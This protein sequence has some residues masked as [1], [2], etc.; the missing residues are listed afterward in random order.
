MLGF[1]AINYLRTMKNVVA[2]YAK[3]GHNLPAAIEATGCDDRFREYAESWVT[4]YEYAHLT[5]NNYR[6]G[7]FTLT[8]CLNTLNDIGL[9]LWIYGDKY[10]W[11]LD[12]L[13]EHVTFELG[14]C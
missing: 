7:L 5:L 6:R 8:E 14:A 11:T 1:S 13:R 9:D 3:N 12:A 2:E 10:T 4:A